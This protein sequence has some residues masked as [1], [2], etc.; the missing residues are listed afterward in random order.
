VALYIVQHN[1]SNF[2]SFSAKSI[3]FLTKKQPGCND[4]RLKFFRVKS[5]LNQFVMDRNH[6][7]IFKEKGGAI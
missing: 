1:Q 5:M 4:N 2:I 3:L 6:V 7:I